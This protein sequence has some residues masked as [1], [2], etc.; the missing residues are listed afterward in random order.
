MKK[1]LPLVSIIM[2]VHNAQ[3]FVAEAI[4]SILEQTYQRFKL[5]IIDD[6][7][8]DK[9]AEI[10]KKLVNPKIVYFRNPKQLGVTKSLTH[11]LKMSKGVFIA[12]MDADD[13]AYPTRLERQVKFLEGHSEVGVLGTAVEVINA[14]GKS[15][16]FRKMPTDSLAIKRTLAWMNPLI[17]PT[18][19]FR[20]SLV[21]RMGTYD[22]DLNGAEDYDLWLRYAK[23]TQIGNLPEVL[24]KYRIH[25]QQV[26]FLQTQLVSQAHWKTLLKAVNK[27]QYPKWYLLAG[28]KGL[29]FRLIPVGIKQKIYAKL[30]T[31]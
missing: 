7:S 12:R 29:L 20:N 19:M 16:G 22:E 21:Q 17:H 3:E 25:R 31:N 15:V 24:L 18:V 6:A 13:I 10:L 26:S 4:R 28:L 8:T 23:S 9:S 5:I 2:P 27:Y 1:Q 14:E 30:F 11:A